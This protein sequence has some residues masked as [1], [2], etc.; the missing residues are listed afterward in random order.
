MKTITDSFFVGDMDIIAVSPVSRSPN[1]N[2]VIKQAHIL[3]DKNGEE[4]YI[5]GNRTIYK[6]LCILQHSEWVPRY[7]NNWTKNIQTMDYRE[8][9]HYICDILKQKKDCFLDFV[10]FE[11]KRLLMLPEPARALPVGIN[12][13]GKTT[14]YVSKYGTTI[15]EGHLKNRTV[16]ETI[17]IDSK[18]NGST[19]RF[20]DIDG[21]TFSAKEKTHW[22]KILEAYEE[23]YSGQPWTNGTLHTG[24][25]NLQ[26]RDR[27]EM[28]RMGAIKRY[29]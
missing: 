3:F 4:H 17:Y 22:P 16:R 18:T 5:Q 24:V 14:G 2:R 6:L 9:V 27:L 15:S 10:K 1:T 19:Y 20:V 25:L 21:Y 26:D 11:G 13:E 23:N 8:F 29:I 7:F 12:N 28:E